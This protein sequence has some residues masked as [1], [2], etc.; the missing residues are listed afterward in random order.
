MNAAIVG[1][2]AELKHSRETKFAA[3]E[4][5][6]RGCYNVEIDMVFQFEVTEFGVLSVA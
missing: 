4:F 1:K 3:T 2:V 5:E 6:V